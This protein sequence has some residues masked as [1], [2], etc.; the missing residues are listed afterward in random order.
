MKISWKS[1]LEYVDRLG[2]VDDK[3]TAMIED[4]LEDNGFP[5]IREDINKLINYAFS[6]STKYGEAAS[7]LAAQ[8]YDGIAQASNAKVPPAAPAPTPE[9]G[10]VAKAINGTLKTGNKEIVSSSIGRLVK[11]TGVDTTQQNALRD[12]AE[13][14]WIPHGDTCAFCI[15]LASRGWQ[16]ASKNA[17]RN[18]H[19]E[20]IHSNCDC[21]Y[22]IRFDSK[23]NVE[24]YDP[25]KYL[26]MYENADGSTPKAKINAMR[27]EF[28]AQNKK[29]GNT[30][31]DAE[32]VNVSAVGNVL[33]FIQPK[34]TPA[35]S[36]SEAEEYAKQ[37][38]NDVNYKGLSLE[39]A[40]KINEELNQLNAKYPIKKLDE[41]FQDGRQ[42][43]IARS[44]RSVLYVNGRKI[45]KPVGIDF[46]L[47]QAMDKAELRNIFA[48]YEGF[49]FEELPWSVQQRVEQLQKS[50]K[51][52]RWSASTTYGTK[53]TIAH[54][55]GHI[56][57]DQYWE[58]L[59]GV[60]GSN[61][62]SRESLEK[63]VTMREKLQK[64]FD[65]AHD[66]GDIFKVSK[67]GATDKEEFFA[68]VFSLR[69]NGEKLPQYINDLIDE[70]TNGSPML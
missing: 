27:R 37:F 22:A 61:N 23:T 65:K 12:G 7:A 13:W 1:W 47:G 64:V 10:E 42:K 46:D 6:V 18:G 4:W 48:K 15:T 69:E 67:Y 70:V 50:V 53:G 26:E 55:Y 56:I 49:G 14:A 24:G 58:M 36:L 68:E 28:Y 35:T 41:L 33:N 11:R 17:L 25:Q 38:A 60:L 31:E 19:A 62:F 34:F 44:N 3:A 5:Q 30:G 45:G 43:S 32:E 40:N 57:C 52:S 20:H 51:Y 9:I 2:K 21:T 54:E 8:M 63:T 39:E 16:R 59:N 66:T 29:V